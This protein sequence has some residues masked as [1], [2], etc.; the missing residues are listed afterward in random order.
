MGMLREMGQGSCTVQA[1]RDHLTQPGEKRINFLFT[2][3][4]TQ[5]KRGQR[6]IFKATF[7]LQRMR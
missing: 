7:Y 3:Q 5:A 6:P 4:V 2:V 1:P